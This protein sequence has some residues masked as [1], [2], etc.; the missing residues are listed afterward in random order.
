MAAKTPPPAPVPPKPAP[1]GS[2]APKPAPR[3][4]PLPG[5]HAPLPSAPPARVSVPKISIEA[6][7]VG[8]GLDPQGHLA[9]PPV[10]D[11]ALVG[12]YQD[13]PSPGEAGTSLLVGHR[14][15]LT[16]PA[17]FLNLNAL[18]PGDLVNVVRVDNRIA[19][20]TVDAV[21]TYKKEAFPDAEVYGNKSG[22][23]ELRVLTCGG[24]F[25]KKK[26]YASNVVVFAHLTDVKPV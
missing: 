7:V 9:T 25:D 26:G 10:D 22:R 14:D 21:K 6:P 3:P 13:G 2:A 1:P 24:T 12:W 15:T 5:A 17:I 20:F 8:M 19:V 23:P 16:G 11:P 4:V 18:K